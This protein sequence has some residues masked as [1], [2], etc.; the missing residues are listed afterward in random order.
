MSGLTEGLEHPVDILKDLM[1]SCGIDLSTE[2]EKELR[3]HCD[4]NIEPTCMTCKFFLKCK[5]HKEKIF[6]AHWPKGKFDI[7]IHYQKVNINSSKLVPL[8]CTWISVMDNHTCQRC[9]ELNGKIMSGRE[10]VIFQKE[11]YDLHAKGKDK[12]RCLIKWSDI[13]QCEIKGCIEPVVMIVRDIKETISSPKNISWR[14][15]EPVGDFHKFCEK[16]KRDSMV[17]D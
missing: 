5:R 7:C 17:F 1:Q 6:P 15:F 13:G 4:E 8:I 9:S 12:C 16:H 3:A 14:E 10:A 11:V 2:Y